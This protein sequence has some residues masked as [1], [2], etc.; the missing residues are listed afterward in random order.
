[1]NAHVICRMGSLVEME[2]AHT[3]RD[4]EADVAVYERLKQLGEAGAEM[5]CRLHV[6]DGRPVL[7]LDNP[8]L[9]EA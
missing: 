7:Q 4:T 9:P 1:M 2:L 3:V 5:R 6:R 8:R